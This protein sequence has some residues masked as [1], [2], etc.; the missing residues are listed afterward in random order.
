M[1]R[2][3]IFGLQLCCI[4]R[5]YFPWR[6]SKSDFAYSRTMGWENETA[7]GRQ[8]Y[9]ARSL[10]SSLE[11]NEHPQHYVQPFMDWALVPARPCQFKGT[12]LIGVWGIYC[13]VWFLC[14]CVWVLCCCIFPE[15]TN[16]L[17]FLDFCPLSQLTDY[18]N[19]SEGWALRWKC[20]SSDLF[21]FTACLPLR[22]TF[23]VPQ[24]VT[25]R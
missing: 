22:F 21:F 20:A 8:R 4:K 18:Q 24:Q 25:V 11:G 17:S 10:S 7:L 9:V 5:N 13:P 23:H 14:V 2:N 12:V 19:L 6:W 16:Y 15:G 1:F 3:K